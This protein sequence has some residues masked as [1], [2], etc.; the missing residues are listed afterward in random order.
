[1]KLFLIIFCICLP[2]LSHSQNGQNR[3]VSFTIEKIDSVDNWYFIYA[4]Y[5]KDLYKI[6]SKRSKAPGDCSKI[7][8]SQKYILKIV[9]MRERL[10]KV[11]GR[12]TNI[13]F[14]YHVRCFGLG[15]GEKVCL[16]DGVKDLAF[17]DDLNGLCYELDG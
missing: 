1:M 14:Q 8:V 15:E 12:D 2:F 4:R 6:A 13:S 3:G 11:S 9:T 17:A 16:E 10:K 7:E 5:E